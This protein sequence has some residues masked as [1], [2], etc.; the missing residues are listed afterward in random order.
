MSNVANESLSALRTV[1]A[2]NAREWEERKFAD[3]VND[4][5]ELGRKEARA[6]AL[7]FGRLSV[8]MIG[9]P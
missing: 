7:F 5:L 2:F 4:V 8:S 1:Q 6:S 3:K 9:M